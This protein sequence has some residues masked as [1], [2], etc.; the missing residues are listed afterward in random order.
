MLI[1]SKHWEFPDLP[2]SLAITSQTACRN[3]SSCCYQPNLCVYSS[4][5]PEL[6]NSGWMK[7]FFSGAPSTAYTLLVGLIPRQVILA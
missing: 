7:H 4:L 1:T 2:P 6:H 5:A 3:S